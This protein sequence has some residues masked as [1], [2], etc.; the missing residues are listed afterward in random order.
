MANAPAPAIA[1]RDGDDV[2]LDR[3]LRSTTVSAGLVI[4][5]RIVS[6]AA[7]GVSNARI[8]ELTGAS[9]ATV[10]KWRTR[11]L[12]VGIAGLADTTRPGRPR[13]VD[14]ADIVAATLTPPSNSH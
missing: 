8:R 12:H 14:H 3:I 6:L 5:A 11:Y 7:Q 10:V 13:R 9:S 4:R 2:E 1:L